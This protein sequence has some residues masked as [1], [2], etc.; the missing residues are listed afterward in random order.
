MM[1]SD[2]IGVFIGGFRDPI[3]PEYYR[4]VVKPLLEKIKGNKTIVYYGDYSFI[5]KLTKRFAEEEGYPLITMKA[6]WKEIGEF[7]GIERNNHVFS[8]VDYAILFWDGFSKDVKYMI[9]A[10][11]KHKVKT[12]L[13]FVDSMEIKE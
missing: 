13:Y 12:K 5:D 4:Y 1:N 11:K 8:S 7:A 9:E 3:E 6:R 2:N 10:I